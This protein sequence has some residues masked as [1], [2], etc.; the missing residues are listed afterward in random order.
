ML[1]RYSRPEMKTLWSE[2]A[3]Y[4]AWAEVEKAHLQTL[5]EA[6]AAPKE[7]VQSFESALKNKCSADFLKREQ[8]TNH[9]VIAFVSEVGDAMGDKGHFLHKG[10]TSSDVVDTSLSIRI[11]KSLHIITNALDLVRAA[12]AQKSFEHA[13]T[14]CIGRTHGIHA[15][16][17]S[18]GQVLASHFCEFQRAHLNILKAKEAMSYGKLSGAV[19]TYSQISPEF[20]L[21]V[22]KK[23]NL[24]PETVATQVIPR[25]RVVVVGH[26]LLSCAQAIER[27]CTNL[28]HW[29]RTEIGE[30][31][32][33]FSK[34][35]KGSSAMP[36]KK[37]PI[38]AENLCGLARSIRGYF[39]ML[40]E[41]VALWHERDI[42]HSSVERLALPDMF[43]TTDFMIDRVCY[44]IE[45]MEI[46]PQAME[47]NLWKT[48]GLWASQ[49]VLT[50][51]VSSGMNRTTAY[52]L[53]QGIALDISARVATGSVE[54]KEFLNKLL[55]NNKIKEIVGEKTV[56][57]LFDTNKY[58]QTVPVSFKRAFGIVPEEYTR[59]QNEAVSE[60][61]PTLHKI[62]KVTVELLPDVLDTEAKTIAQDL[63]QTEPQVL[64][65]RQQK[66]FF[67][68][69]P[70][71]TSPEQITKYA[72]EVLHNAVME[73]VHVE[74]IQ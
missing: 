1:D 18:F 66:N 51:L 60:K 27:F 31:L 67:V 24:K 7:T 37:N 32:E 45:N 47:N 50:A 43:I 49:S 21:S 22:L 26:A 59:K 69:I 19:G 12:L 9:D 71:H 58:L 41:N 6:Q 38:F 63:K 61:V 72:Q 4:S 54:Q 73:Q 46:R 5:V 74:V 15:E 53:V 52:E 30:V 48:G 16:P 20:E 68:R 14:I 39:N 70:F 10:L 36:H 44:L 8:E 17:M 57:S 2:E 35:Q 55:A 64:D 42:S 25:D 34:K 65:L 28:R 3:K 11:Q 56:H 40:S 13:S 23:L 29:A 33:P 62:V